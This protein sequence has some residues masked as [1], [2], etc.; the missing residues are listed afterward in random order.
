MRHELLHAICISLMRTFGPSE[1]KTVSPEPARHADGGASVATKFRST[2]GPVESCWQ[3]I[4]Q[5]ELLVLIYR[6]NAVCHRQTSGCLDSPS[7]ALR[8]V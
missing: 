3:A 6:E 2:S 7:L 1:L 5:S 8:Q 4:P